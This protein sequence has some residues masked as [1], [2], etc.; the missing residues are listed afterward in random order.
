MR[1][2]DKGK[3]RS[4]ERGSMV[5][6]AAIGMVGLSGL[7]ALALDAGYM[8]VTRAEIQNVADV[9]A[10][11]GTLELARI[12][13]D[14]PESYDFKNHTL[15]DAD[16]GRITAAVN[17]FSTQN[18]A[19]GQSISIGAGDI[20]L[21]VWDRASR[22]FTATNTGVTAVR[23]KARRDNTTNG[24]VSTLM[25][26]VIGVQDFSTT[27]SAMGGI[28]GPSTLGAGEGEFP[29]G[30]DES[31]FLARNSPC[32]TNSAIEFH[33]TGTLVG[34]AG[35]HT[36]EDAPANANKLKSILTQM[37]SDSYTSPELQVGETYYNFTGGTVTSALQKAR[38]L[39]DTKK[40]SN[41][42]WLVHIPVYQAQGCSNPHGW[43]KIIG[44]AAATI[45]DVD[46]KGGDKGIRANVSC[47]IIRTG[48]PGGPSDY[49]VL[50]ARSQFLQ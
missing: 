31:W 14:L 50:V 8:M 43:L 18:S 20:E 5:I 10:N 28:S 45:Y 46:D 48:K 47:D 40:D 32:G 17:A 34:C 41:G 35:W 25:G 29:V 24:V 49:G 1:A 7:A 42:N 3:A 21:G 15:S 30:I 16:K 2:P 33:P 4:N 22:S 11:S 38:L 26:S 44:V 19:A 13:E 12:Y 36:F 39:Y 23:V 6:F 27:A 9:G 37:K